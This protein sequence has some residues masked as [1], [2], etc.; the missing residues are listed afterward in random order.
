MLK[1]ISSWIDQCIFLLIYGVMVCMLAS[2]N[3]YMGALGFV[4]WL[5]M[6]A[7]AI[8][9]ARDREQKFAAYIKHVTRHLRSSMDYA[10]ENLP[11]A[12]FIIDD[13]GRLQWSNETL[14]RFLKRKPEHGSFIQD[15]FAN[16]KFKP[17]WNS[18]GEYYFLEEKTQIAYR[19]WYKP[20]AAHSSD[21]AKD[22]KKLA[23][24]ELQ[25]FMIFYLQNI[26]EVKKMY[27][28]YC[29]SRTAFGYIQI[30]N[31]DEVL[32]GLTEAER[33][34]ILFNVNRILDEWT[35]DLGAVLRR[36]NDDLYLMI[37]ERSAL[38]KPFKDKFEILDKVRTLRGAHKLSVTLSLGIAVS[39]EMFAFETDVKE[40][41]TEGKIFLQKNMADL[42]SKAQACLDLALGRGGDQV[43]VQVDGKTQ[44]FGGKAQAV[45]KHTR[46]K[47]RVVAHA[48]KELIVSSDEVYV[49]GHQ[50]ED[51]DAL[52]AAIGVTKMVKENGKPVH[53]ILSAMNEGIDKLVDLLK[54]K[55]EHKDLFM[56]PMETL[57]I[58]A[59]NPLLIVVDT[60]IPY[61]T[62][63]PTFLEKIK[64]VAVIDHHRRSSSCIQNPLLFY[65]EPSSSST[66]EL[67][68]ELLM[69]LENEIPL[70]RLEATAL[71]SGII[72][73]T[74]YFGVQ[75]GV[76]TFEAAAYL[77]RAGADPVIIRYLFRADYDTSLA[78]AKAEASSK[79]YD[80]GLIIAT[81]P[82]KIPNIQAIA[83]QT[84]DSLLRIENVRMSIVVFQLKPDVV[85]ISAR[86]LGELN[87][88]VI[89]EEFG[90]GGHQNVAGAQVHDEPLADVLE[91]VVA[92][93]KKHIAEN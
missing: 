8:E 57:S 61:L 70:S 73:D 59:K 24:D 6:I 56:T 62:A 82:E 3:L 22:K 88:Q 32:Q 47:A 26:S 89:M 63:A 84:A 21:F 86:S 5:C 58:T 92:S 90:G 19:V 17:I 81:C 78:M 10:V 69:Y 36:L 60:H 40:D 29:A 53:I 25:T 1:N 7:F 33:T 14:T 67:V 35:R 12:I 23:E 48:L 80:G 72:V 18:T 9:R 27:D 30:D 37:C 50:N 43:A 31:F 39:D 75:T 83:A 44:F 52:G 64:R 46:V 49:M 34:G 55:D 42:S 54:E 76:R 2:Q 38:E 13:Q 20:L 28:A 11:Q 16:I 71:Y 74:K 15:Y 65:V 51:F 77:R 79:L 93:A 68:T 66:S 85:G 87:V 4:V 45:E 41:D 91:R